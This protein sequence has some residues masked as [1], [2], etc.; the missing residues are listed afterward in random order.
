M[1]P[2]TG[3]TYAIHLSHVLID[4]ARGTLS[5]GTTERSFGPRPYQTMT[6]LDAFDVLLTHW[7]L[8]QVEAGYQEFGR[9]LYDAVF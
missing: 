6:A 4:Q 8:P 9:P 7:V 3:S 1:V 2:G 5:P